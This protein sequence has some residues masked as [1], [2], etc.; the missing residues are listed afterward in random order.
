MTDAVKREIAQNVIAARRELNR[1]LSEAHLVG[2]RAEVD[3]VES[4]TMCRPNARV[5]VDVQ[6]FEKIE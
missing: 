1:R 5:Q 3:V 6:L 2:L 4:Q